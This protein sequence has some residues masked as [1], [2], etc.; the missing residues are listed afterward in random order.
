MEDD[1][2]CRLLKKCT[3]FKISIWDLSS[4]YIPAISLVWYALYSLFQGEEKRWTDIYIY[5]YVSQWE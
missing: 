4:S 3:V 1:L 2:I 5:I